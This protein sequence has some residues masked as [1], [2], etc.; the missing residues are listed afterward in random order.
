M[1]QTL[2]DG[3]PSTLPID[4]SAGDPRRNLLAAASALA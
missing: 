1:I 4:W 2:L 3:N